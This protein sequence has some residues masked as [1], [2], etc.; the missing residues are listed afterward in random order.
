MTPK[1]KLMNTKATFDETVDNLKLKPIYWYSDNIP[2]E[3]KDIA[4]ELYRVHNFFLSKNSIFQ[5]QVDNHILNLLI[6]LRN[7]LVKTVENA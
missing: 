4:T 1:A 7:N 2:D 3:F 5:E 6:L